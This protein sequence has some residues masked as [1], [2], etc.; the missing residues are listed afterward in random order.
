MNPTAKLFAAA[1]LL[2]LGGCAYQVD[3]GPL[4]SQIAAAK[5]GDWGTCYTHIHAAAESLQKAEAGL[6]DIKK[7]SGV[8]GNP[9]RDKAVAN[10]KAA[11]AAR[12]KA[13]MA[14]NARTAALEAK[15]PGIE[16][17]LD[18]HDA[19][20]QALEA[21]HELMTGVTFHTGSAKLTKPSVAALDVIGNIMLRGPVDAEVAGHASTP[22]SSAMN[23]RL[24]TARANTVRKHL[25]AMGVN[26]KR[27][28]A[29]GYGDTWPVAD[30]NTREGQ[31]ANQRVELNFK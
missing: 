24:S 9:M 26:G 14:C 18:E 16:A 3:Y 22:G 28:T 6:A 20:L 8:Y 23:K 4:E 21:M 5:S 30:N 25:M 2:T 17:R 1:S 7:V 29:K 15:M 19:R 11:V 13:D 27:L 31:R 12:D 10:V